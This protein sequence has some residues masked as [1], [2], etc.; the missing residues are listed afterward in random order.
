[1]ESEKKWANWL[2]HLP[3]SPSK[4]NMRPTVIPSLTQGENVLVLYM[5]QQE[6]YCMK[7]NSLP[8]HSQ[9]LISL[10]WKII[11]KIENIS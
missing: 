9:N 10:K 5:S 7:Q 6:R 3:L 8:K 4:V 1:M 2:S 11:G